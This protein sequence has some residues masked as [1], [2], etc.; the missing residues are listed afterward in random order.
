LKNHINNSACILTIGDEILYGQILD[1]NARHL[2][3][4]LSGAGLEI[5]MK[6]VAGD[7]RESILDA[8][9]IAFE[10]VDILVITGGL[11]PTNDDLTKPLL[12][13]WFNDKLEIRSIAFSHLETLLKK[14]G[15]EMTEMVKSQAFLPT[16]AEYLENKVGTAPGMWFQE[17]GKVAIALPGVPYEMKQIIEDQVLPRI[18]ERVDVEAL[19]HGWIRTI[20]VPE[21]F[22]A[23]KISEWEKNLPDHLKLAY[24]PGGGQVRLRL[25]GRGEELEF[26]S[27]Q[28]ESEL[29]KIVPLIE[30]HVYA[31]TDVELDEVLAPLML[32]GQY[33]ISIQDFLTKGRLLSILLRHPEIEKQICEHPSQLP[34]NKVFQVSIKPEKEMDGTETQKI[35]VGLWYQNHMLDSRIREFRPFQQVEIN[36]NMLSLWVLQCIRLIIMDQNSK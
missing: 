21:S 26:L 36:Q 29:D 9:A 10:R 33:F 3:E 19:Y 15:R 14:R 28:V 30:E 2:A 11:G 27:K 16:Q 32:E 23:Q 5:K 25:T 35:E 1:T 7:S 34:E 20:G 13:E 24:L 22:L 12:A 31:R 17:N 18:K 8:F 6:M 4:V